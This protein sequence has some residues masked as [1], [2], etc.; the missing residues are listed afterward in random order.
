[1][2]TDKTNGLVHSVIYDIPSTRADLPANV[3]KT[4]QP[5][6]VPGAKQTTAYDNTTRG[7]LGPCPPNEHTYELAL[8]ALDVAAL[9]GVTMGTTRAQI[10]PIIAA[11]DVG[12]ARLTGK[13][14]Q[15]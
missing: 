11:H 5:A 15:P 13:Y 14:K 12:V 7:Y 6:N 10:V 1:M 8:H 2:F 9:P 3:A 4:Y